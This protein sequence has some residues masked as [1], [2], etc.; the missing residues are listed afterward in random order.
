MNYLV[1]YPGRFHPFHLGHK[2]SYDWLVNKFGESSVYIAT[3]NVQAENSP[4]SFSDKLT[5]MTKLGVPA[6]HVVQVKNP[7]Q[8]VEITN[9][10]S[11]EEKKTTA[12]IFAVSQKDTARFNFSP[13]KDGSPS[14]LQPL[15]ENIKKLKPMTQHGYVVVTPTVNFKVRGADADS[16][17][18]VRE[19]YAN[20]N[21]NDRTSIITDLY[22]TPDSELKAIFDKR[23]AVDKPEQIVTYG[24]EAIDGGTKEFG[25][26]RQQRLHKLSERIKKLKQHIQ[27]M[28][29]PKNPDYIDEKINR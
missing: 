22:G 28:R 11:D 16:A 18:K 24:A 9:G 13:K 29:Q 14:Y 23:L 21:D 26:S 19:L 2:A 5:M 4:F 3:S 27:E 8:A 17:S 20:G 7:Y 15:P 12:L 10:L 1:I 6:S 25:E